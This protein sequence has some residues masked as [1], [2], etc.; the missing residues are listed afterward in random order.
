MTT[1][2]RY[3]APFESKTEILIELLTVRIES[4]INKGKRQ[5]MLLKKPEKWILH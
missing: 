4:E 3:K 2:K 5:M 1:T